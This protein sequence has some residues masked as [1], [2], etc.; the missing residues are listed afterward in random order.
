MASE[1][2]LS[3]HD[4]L[5]I[6]KRRLWQII[7]IF[8]AIV[9]LA[10]VIALMMPP[11]FESKGTILVESQQISSD[12]VKSN[13]Q[14][15][16]DERIEVIKQRVMTRENLYR[17]INKYELFSDKLE[18]QSISEVISEMRR[19]INVSLLNAR[20]GGGHGN[21]TI[22]F[23]VSFEDRQPEIAHKVANELV[24]L[25]LDENVKA[26]TEKATETTEFLSQEV[27]TLRKNLETTET[28]VAEYKEKHADS[29]PEH[30]NMHMTMLERVEREIND[31]NREY[32]TV[33]EELRYLDVELASA[34]ADTNANSVSGEPKKETVE[35]ELEKSKL[36]LERALAL[37][38]EAHPTVKALKRNIQNL[39]KAKLDN[40]SDAEK[41]VHSSG[42]NIEID[43][44]VAKIEAQI[45]AAQARLTS[46]SN[47]KKLL[48]SKVINL[49]S[50]ISTSP[51]VEKGLLSLMR[52]YQNAKSK[53]EEVKSKQINAKIAE[54]LEQENKAERFSMLEPPIFPEKPIRPNRKKILLLGLLGGLAASLGG[55]LLLESINGSIRSSEALSLVTNARTMAT[56]P[57][58][59]TQSEVRRRKYL[60]KYITMALIGAFLI[61]MLLIH[62]LWM[63]LD[64]LMIKIVNRFS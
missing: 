22:A 50:R 3:L 52:D 2:E 33:Q 25:F 34:K 8:T 6:I 24:T 16:A 21:T 7:V 35:T 46:L 23:H 29:L 53:Y 26:R 32:K 49:Q 11:V 58:V 41:Q 39:E 4:Y 63:P 51:T 20:S 61:G 10:A 18:K 57:Y 17:I 54:N 37:Y 44:R 27:E 30:R 1:Y 9:T 45:E 12:F 64:L 48:K 42:E 36:E 13:Q 56:I 15:F 14:S 60:Y 59:Y 55:V 62:F 38:S 40:K 47:Q 31:I 19:A 28:K 43:L 5:S